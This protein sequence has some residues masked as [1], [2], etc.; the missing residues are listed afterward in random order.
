M[1]DHQPLTKAD[2]ASFSAA[3]TAAMTASIKNALAQQMDTLMALV[4]AR[5][6][7]N[8]NNMNRNRRS[9]GKE[10]RKCPHSGNNLRCSSFNVSDYET[11]RRRKE[12]STSGGHFT[13]Y[14][15]KVSIQEFFNL[16]KINPTVV[17]LTPPNN[18]AHSHT[19][20]TTASR[21]E[22]DTSLSGVG[23]VT[24]SGEEPSPQSPGEAD[25]ISDDY[26]DHIEN[27]E[28]LFEEVAGE[29][30]EEPTATVEG[31][32]GKLELKPEQTLEASEEVGPVTKLRDGEVFLTCESSSSIKAIFF[33]THELG[34]QSPFG[35]HY[36]A[37]YLKKN[38]RSSSLEVEEKVKQLEA[39]KYE[40]SR[41]AIDGSQQNWVFDP[42]IP[43]TAMSSGRRFFYYYRTRGR[44]LHKKRSLMQE[45]YSYFCYF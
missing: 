38:L 11:P 8:G 1:G 44:V 3:I 33:H 27:V 23:D 13:I 40:A 35:K 2:L 9:R 28:V 25:V 14:N 26:S 12:K 29:E 20:S 4:M 5:A 16:H 6:N 37:F 17:N 45:H 32:S 22:G 24:T 15:N 36:D 7:N 30:V 21:T 18:K 31:E 42:G 34:N 19:A 39:R 41:W 43:V 10:Q